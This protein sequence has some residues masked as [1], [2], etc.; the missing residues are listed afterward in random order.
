MIAQY[1]RVSV[2]DVNRVLRAYLDNRRVVTAYAVPKNA[3]VTSSGS[4]QLAKENNEI[5]PSK[6]EPLPEWAQHVLDNL[7]VPEQTFSPADTTLA[8]GIRLIVVPEHIS[9]TVVVDGAIDNDPRVQVPP[10]KEGVDAVTDGLFAYG[11]T[12]Y[13]RLAFARELD[14][15]AASTSA[16]TDFGLDVLSSDLDR[17]VALLADQELHPAFR[18]SDFAIVRDQ[19]AGERAGEMT[20][21]DFLAQLALDKALYPASDDTQRRATPKTIGALSLEDVKAWYAS[22][23]RPDLT[24]IVVIGDTT[25]ENAK[26]VVEKYFG[27]WKAQGP[28]PNVNLPPVPQNVSNQTDVPATGR[29][30]SSVRLVETLPIVRT[31]PAFPLLALANTVL[32]G[33][34]YSSLLYHDLREV[35][36]YVY[37][38]QS[39]VAAGRTRSTF[40]I[41]YGCD[42]KNILPAQA[43]IATILAQLQSTPIEPDRLLRSKAL[44]MGEVPIRESSYDGVTAELLHYA[45]LGLPLDQNVV[46]AGAELNASSESVRGAIARYVR[47]DGF[48]RIV[49]GPP[50]P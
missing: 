31:D 6:H 22:A 34:F 39:N 46:D 26:A 25:P 21:P 23:Y 16:G 18:E 44:L 35:R 4:G 7:H 5:P 14:R 27:A 2:A 40:G 37:D 17:G 19:A 38:V 20:S 48:V 36:G 33:G 11:T 30:Q 9:H 49:T 29:V 13:D 45:T 41:A 3:G 32:T 8:N 28:K 50:P 42:P 47:P 24:T 1:Q 10:G 43:Q 15:I 12:S